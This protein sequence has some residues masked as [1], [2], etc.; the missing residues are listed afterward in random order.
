[1]EKHLFI[2]AMLCSLLFA[3]KEAPLEDPTLGKTSKSTPT[4]KQYY[5][6]T[7]FAGDGKPGNCDGRP[8]VARFDNPGGLAAYSDGSLL[9]ADMFNYK[10]RKVSPTGVV[11]TF[12]GG[13]KGRIDGPLA[14]AQFEFPA[15]VA[16]APN[17][18]IYV[19]ELGYVR[20]IKDGIVS[21]IPLNQSFGS[22]SVIAVSPS[23]KIYI[24]HFDKSQILRISEDGEIVVVAGSDP[25]FK[26]GIG[27]SAKFK[28]PRGLAIDLDETIYVADSQN[29]RIRK[30]SPSGVVTT[31][32][33]DGDF[34]NRDGQ[35]TDAS[36]IRPE[37][38]TIAKDGNL[39][40]CGSNGDLKRI[41]KSGLVTTLET[42]TFPWFSTNY[43]TSVN[44]T[45]FVVDNSSP[46]IFK[47][48]LY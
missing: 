32:A 37:T 44:N 15:G 28:N 21:T 22:G 6:F 43:I 46:K 35:G 7:P 2:G 34:N 31:L 38:L 1:M 19:L 3:C 47:L 5:Q 8:N 10:I 36:F 14:Q 9:V 40:L 26:D 41:T 30:I 27:N 29:R 25:G 16:I 33:G 39:Y 24:S 12:A 18:T 11:S 42:T 17:G 23:G 45:L 13:K 48:D 4:I 20:K